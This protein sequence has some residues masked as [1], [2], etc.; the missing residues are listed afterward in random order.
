MTMVGLIGLLGIRVSVVVS[1][2]CE[3]RDE[4]EAKGDEVLIGVISKS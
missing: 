3:V 4:G 1:D 2:G